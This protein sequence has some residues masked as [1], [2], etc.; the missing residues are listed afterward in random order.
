VIAAAGV[1]AGVWML[2]RPTL[3]PPALTARLAMT[4]PDDQHFAGL[5]DTPVL[6]ISP[7]GTLV[8]YV[9]VAS[10][11]QQLYVRAIDSAESKAFAGTDQAINPFF[12]PDG[13]W[14]GFFAQGKL[15][16]VSVA[17][18]TTQTLCDAP[19]PRGGS[20]AGDTIY[21]A[22]SSN[23]MIS[24]VSAD[25]GAPTDVTTLDRA[26]G[27]VSHRWPQMLPDGKTLLFDVWK[28]PAADEKEIHVQRMEGGARTTVVQAG[29]SGRYV[30]SGHVIYARNDE[31]F[32]VPFDVDHL[33]VT[34]QASRLRDAARRGSEGNHYAVSDNGV[35][36]SVSGSPDRNERRLVW[37]RRDGSV[38]PLA[39][40]PRDYNGNA[41]ISPDGRRAAVDIEGG[42]VSVWLYDFMR[43][44][45]TPLTT[46]KGSSQAPRW[47]PD[48]THIVYRGTRTG[49]RNLWWKGVDDAKG[50]ERLTTGEGVQT[51]GSFSNDGWLAY[52]DSDPATGFDIVALP[53]GGDRK[54]RAVAK[55]Q[56]AEQFP[57]LSPDGHW[58]AYTSNESG[59]PEVLVQSFPEAGARTQISTNGGIEPV[60][61]RD[62]RELFYLDGDAMKAVDVRTSPTFSAGAPRL[63]FEGRYVQ[64][65]NGVAS[66]DVSADGQRFLRVQPLHP[67]PPTHEIQVTVN[68]FEE[69]K[70]LVPTK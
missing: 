54:P 2:S 24:K 35:F 15:K 55:T 60:W 31:L 39:A 1:G 26:R 42:T 25:G 65:P 18:G 12:S 19:N 3:A 5:D 20:W 56:F 16:K 29:A 41:V 17:T 32:A 7:K 70:R 37:V 52:Y 53:V 45:L 49:S 34:G 14:I 28:G 58:I 8:A 47:T 10:G 48:G 66:Y 63:L 46:G 59:R 33:R 57:R 69:L 27:E 9:A 44:T 21:F 68:W 64:S 50:E 38:E 13:Q 23:S 51:P 36:V 40:P 67:D 43:G 22:A 61:S 4:L 6:A 30:A 11:R 62:G